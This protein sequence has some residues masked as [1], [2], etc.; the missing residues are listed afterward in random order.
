M[1]IIDLFSYSAFGRKYGGGNKG[2]GLYP[3]SGSSSG[4]GS[5]EIDKCSVLGFSE[6]LASFRA[7]PHDPTTGMLFVNTVKHVLKVHH[8]EKEEKTS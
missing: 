2:S 8:W 5:D 1:K 7:F 3:H 6:L 4:E